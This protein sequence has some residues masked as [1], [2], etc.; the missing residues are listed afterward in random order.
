MNVGSLL[1]LTPTINFAHRSRVD[2]D[3]TWGPRTIPDWQFFYVIEGEAELLY[4]QKQQR[5]RAG[6]VC[7]LVLT[8]RIS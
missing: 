4:N 6:S 1:T 3:V 2:A 8:A 5:I 7:S